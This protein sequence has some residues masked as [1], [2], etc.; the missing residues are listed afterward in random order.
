M[1]ENANPSQPQE[2]VHDTITID[3]FLN[4]VKLKTAKVVKVEDIPGKD[5]LYHL[6]I[7]VGEETRSLVA[8][9][10]EWYAPEE[11]LGKTIVLVANLEP[12]KLGG[13]LSQ[14]MLLG[15]L[16][17]EGNFSLMIAEKPVKSGTE[18]R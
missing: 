12:K 9:I 15:V 8:G 17:D 3:Q 5:K 16:D 10:K 13:V 2:S 7:E 6:T 14:G 11:I 18:V 1:D 4:L